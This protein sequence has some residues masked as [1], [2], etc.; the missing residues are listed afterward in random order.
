MAIG[1]AAH[2]ALLTTEGLPVDD[3]QHTENISST[4]P[5]NLVL[6]VLSSETA[7]EAGG[8]LI[9]AHAMWVCYSTGNASRKT[10]N[11]SASGTVCGIL[12]IVVAT[13]GVALGVFLPT[14]LKRVGIV[15]P[16]HCGG[17]EL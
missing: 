7:R 10:R 8:A 11:T 13:A 5:E 17:G 16:N 14:Y 6:R 1:L 4:R 15:V 12:S 3:G 9:L 2:S